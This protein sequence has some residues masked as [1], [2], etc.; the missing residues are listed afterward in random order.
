MPSPDNLA[1][2]WFEDVWNK[3]DA[4]AIVALSSPDMKAFG[5]DGIVRSRESFA[6]FHGLMLGAVP[7]LRVTIDQS[8][9]GLVAVVARE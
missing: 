3:K 6:E 9:R 7:D 2:R 5:A 8:V 1:R 4:S